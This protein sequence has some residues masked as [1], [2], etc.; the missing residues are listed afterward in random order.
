ML[1]KKRIPLT[2]PG[3]S[4]RG[5]CLVCTGPNATPNIIPEASQMMSASVL[6]AHHQSSDVPRELVVAERPKDDETVVSGIT[7]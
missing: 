5:V 3:K 2:V 6:D 1:G 7:L 4:L